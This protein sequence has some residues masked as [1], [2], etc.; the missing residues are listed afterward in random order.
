MRPS[1]I[2]SAVTKPGKPKTGFGILSQAPILYL[3]VSGKDL[4]SLS[5]FQIIGIL[6]TCSG[7]R[8]LSCT[9]SWQAAAPAFFPE[10][11]FSS[12]ETCPLTLSLMGRWSDGVCS[13]WL[14]NLLALMAPVQKSQLPLLPLTQKLLGPL[15]NCRIFGKYRKAQRKK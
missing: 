5:M 3:L 10:V 11:V 8:V 14:E 7:F 15:F 9:P 6:L 2:P 1:F 12:S 13:F 4:I